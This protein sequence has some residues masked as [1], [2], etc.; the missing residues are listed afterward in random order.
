MNEHYTGFINT[1]VGFGMSK[2]AADTLYKRAAGIGELIGL[3]NKAMKGGKSLAQVMRRGKALTPAQI[4]KMRRFV[5]NSDKI[6]Q[7]GG[8]YFK[9]EAEV[10]KMRQF[11]G[12]GAPKPLPPAVTG[13]GALPSVSSARVLPSV[14]A[15]PTPAVPVRGA[16]SFRPVARGSAMP[17]ASNVNPPPVAGVRGGV[18]PNTGKPPVN[19]SGNGDYIDVESRFVNPAQQNAIARREAIKARFSARR[20]ASRGTPPGD[21]GL[22]ARQQGIKERFNA[23]LQAARTGGTPPDPGVQPQVPAAAVN[24]MAAGGAPMAGGNLFAAHPWL[25]A[26]GIAVPSYVAGRMMANRS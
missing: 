14:P 16:R 7:F 9:N 21:R 22:A 2:E 26:A 25:T 15:A 6:K 11:L 1:C 18:P 17:P 13:G 5:G 4:A 10:A 12:I 19:L 20:A 23:R 8:Q 3:A 24:E